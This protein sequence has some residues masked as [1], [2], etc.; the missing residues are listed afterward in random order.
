MSPQSKNIVLVPLIIACALFMEHLDSS[1]IATALPSIAESLKTDPLHLNLAITSYLFSLA[2]FIPLS[3]WTADRYGARNVFRAAIVIFT[4]ASMACGFATSLSGLVVARLLQGMGGAMM[5]PVGRLV[6]LRSVEKENLLNAMAWFTAPALLGPVLGPPLGGFIVTYYSWRWI[7]FINLPIGLLG[8]YL[9][10]RFIG[11]IR[12]EER[13]PLDLRGFALMALALGGLVVGF[14]MAGRNLVSAQ[15][16]AA[17]ILAGTLS[18]ILYAFHARKTEAPIVDLSLF[19]VPTFRINVLGGSLFRLGTGAMPFLL[20]LLFQIGFGY[21][22]FHSGLLTFLTS[23]GAVTMKLVAT[24]L[25]RRFG[26]R[27]ILMHNAWIGSL[28]FVAYT[29]F[30]KDMSPWVIGFV[31]FWGGFGRSI[32]FTAIN[33]L[34]FADIPASHMS[35]AATLATMMQQLSLSFGVAVG[36]LTLNLTLGGRAGA[37]LQTADFRPS[38]WIVA[39]IS[40]A[41]FFSFYRLSPNAGAEMSGHRAEES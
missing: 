29:Y 32:Q 20:P 5:V 23:A 26:F 17:S 3:G 40:A 24:P 36:A 18:F 10:T 12:E 25:L 19:R 28:F 27:R 30:T 11:D 7:F 34:A 33:T 1:I 15:I 4:V 35:R 31:L 9:A 13:T 14:E 2:L 37:L 6:L 22:A 16:I 8:I 21:S 41:S 38:F 39:L